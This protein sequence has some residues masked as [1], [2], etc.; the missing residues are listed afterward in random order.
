M[1]SDAADAEAEAFGVG[2]AQR[3]PKGRISSSIF[4]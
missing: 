4:I 2:K 3:A 1:M